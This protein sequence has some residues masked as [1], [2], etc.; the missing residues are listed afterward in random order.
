MSLNF[1]VQNAGIAWPS[2]LRRWFKAPVTSVAWVRIPPLSHCLESTMISK[3]VKNVKNDSKT[4][5]RIFFTP[6]SGSVA[7]WSKAL[8]LGTSHFGGVGSNP[9]TIIRVF[10]VENGE[11][12]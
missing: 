9:T 5:L 1:P 7:E 2:G 10:P 3:N 6:R 11:N 12:N 8:V 4:C